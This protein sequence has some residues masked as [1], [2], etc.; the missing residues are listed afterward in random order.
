MAETYALQA[1]LGLGL[2][3]EGGWAGAEAGS[4]FEPIVG[5]ALGAVGGYD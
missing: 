1:L 2:G 3:E 4:T 5:Y